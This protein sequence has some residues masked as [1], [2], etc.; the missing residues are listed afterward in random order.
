MPFPLRRVLAGFAFGAA[1]GW[2]AGLLRTPDAASP[3]SS[4]GAA[5]RLP[6]REF[7]SPPDDGD[8]PLPAGTQQEGDELTVAADGPARRRVRRRVGAGEPAAVP[9]A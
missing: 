4:A 3:D 5:A 9:E 1:A 7:G 6:Q 8:G 2:V